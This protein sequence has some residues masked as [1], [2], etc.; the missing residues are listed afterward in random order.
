MK[1]FNKYVSALVVVLAISSLE[2]SAQVKYAS[3]DE[4]HDAGMGVERVARF[5]IP[6]YESKPANADSEVRWIQIDLG[7][8][9]KIDGVKLLPKVVPWGYVQSEGFPS[10]FKIEVSDDPDFSSP[11]MYLDQTREEFR[12]PFD[13]VCTF[14][15][16]EVNA[17]YLRLTA[18]RL[19]QKK[20]SFTK[21]M[22]LSDGKDIAEG[23]RAS[24]SESG[25]LKV[26]LLTRPPR[27]Q[28]EYVVTDNPG[29]ITPK[30]KWNT[31]SY[32][33]D[34]PKTG[35]ELDEG[36]FRKTM[37][38]NISYLMSS[39]TFD[40]LVRNFRVK[41]GKPVKPLEERLNNFWFVDLPGQEAGRFLMGAGNTLRW[42][43]N[44]DLRKR[45]D[46]IVNVIDE[47]KEPDGYIMAYPKYR[48][49]SGEYGAYKIVG[50]TRTH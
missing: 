4:R 21:V 44:A 12:D 34:V 25:E 45:M 50:Y 36:L 40:E 33:A 28:G 18:V 47:C 15:G 8:M 29:N 1:N 30:E 24:D 35:V 27:P 11:V 16:K 26:N 13:E 7:A 31:A 17:R 42:M 48:I 38:N 14:S 49:F 23:C 19:R 37:E 43:E 32:K 10:R 39:F 46:Q 5:F 2:I 22:V 20:L 6:A 41:A 9:K 3:K